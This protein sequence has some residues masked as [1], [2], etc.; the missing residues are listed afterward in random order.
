MYGLK[1][2][3]FRT[4]SLQG[5]FLMRVHS[6]PALKRGANEFAAANGYGAGVVFLPVDG[7]P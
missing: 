4:P 5:S 2:V 3:P 1:P 7:A 6:F